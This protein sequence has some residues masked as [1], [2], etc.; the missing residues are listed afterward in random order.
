MLDIFFVVI[1]RVRDFFLK[2]MLVFCRRI[3]DVVIDFMLIEVYGY[4]FLHVVL[5]EIFVFDIV[6]EK[7]KRFRG[8]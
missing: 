4:L 5:I 8:N 1:L 3:E 7:E 6:K 2:C